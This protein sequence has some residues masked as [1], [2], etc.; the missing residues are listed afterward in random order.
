MFVKAQ[1]GNSSIIFASKDNISG[2]LM[3]GEAAIL[4]L[5]DGVYYGLN[6]VGNR[7]WKLI[8]VPI[9]VGELV[10]KLLD[11]YDIDQETCYQEVVAL[12]VELAKRN[13]VDIDNG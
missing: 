12:V 13:L 9:S 4:N 1:I 11:E 5:K 7:I 10:N 2:D 3:D 8:H 6:S